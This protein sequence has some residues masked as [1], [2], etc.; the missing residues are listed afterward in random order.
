MTAAVT[1]GFTPPK[2]G[3][4]GGKTT[5]EWISGLGFITPALIIIVIFI[6]IPMIFSFVISFT[7]WTG[8]QPPSEATGVGLSNY[9]DLITS[10]SVI[11]AEFFKALKNTAYY[12]L[13]VV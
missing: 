10:D 6:F 11:R 8:L 2:P 4:L 13:G 9:Q 3:L 1:T 12:A 5:Q 7:N